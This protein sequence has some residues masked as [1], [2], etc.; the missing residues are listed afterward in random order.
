MNC[1]FR[2]SNPI[3]V[4][5][6]QIQGH[7]EASTTVMR[8]IEF[9]QEGNSPQMCI[10]KETLHNHWKEFIITNQK[11]DAAPSCTFN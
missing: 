5:Q 8:V 1:F 6:Y 2:G 7:S 3:Y 4:K 11:A 10:Y 9:H